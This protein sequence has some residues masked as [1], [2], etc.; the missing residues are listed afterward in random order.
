MKTTFSTYWGWSRISEWGGG[1]RLPAAIRL[2]D[3]QII[4]LSWVEYEGASHRHFNKHPR[5]KAK[6]MPMNDDGTVRL[7]HNTGGDDGGRSSGQR[8]A[9]MEVIAPK[10]STF[11][12]GGICSDCGKETV[13]YSEDPN[14]PAN[15]PKCLA[16]YA[17]LQ[18]LV[19]ESQRE[20]QEQEEA[21]ERG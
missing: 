6:Y 12:Y 18:Q 2:P 14:S 7:F 3:G 10:G 16:I 5:S 15:C 4:D 13:E 11:L 8:W 17:E 9:V 19:D 20:L 21:W 1:Q